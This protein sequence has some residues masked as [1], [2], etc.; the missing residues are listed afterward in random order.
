[1]PSELVP[2]FLCP[3]ISGRDLFLLSGTFMFITPLE[4]RERLAKFNNFTRHKPVLEQR[5]HRFSLFLTDILGH[6]LSVLRKQIS[7]LCPSYGT[8][9]DLLDGTCYIERRKMKRE[10]GGTI[11]ERGGR[12]EPNYTTAKKGWAPM[13]Y[14]AI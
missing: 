7:S 8:E 11:G 5:L 12:L 10:R 2:S 9:E 14:I 1:M 6:L 4:A 3:P 13:F